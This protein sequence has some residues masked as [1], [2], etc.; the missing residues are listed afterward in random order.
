MVIHANWIDQTICL[1]GCPR[2]FGGLQWY[3]VCPAQ[4][5]CVSVL[6]SLPGRR[7][8]ERCAGVGSVGL[9]LTTLTFAF[10][11][12]AAGMRSLLRLNRRKTHEPKDDV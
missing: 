3:L 4:N 9:E 10:F 12:S 2:H 11:R 6:W 8:F 7:F 1:V 5:R